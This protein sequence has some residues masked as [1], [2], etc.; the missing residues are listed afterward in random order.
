MA[1]V[2]SN[3]SLARERHMTKLK[4]VSRDWSF[5]EPEQLGCHF[6]WTASDRFLQHVL[7]SLACACVYH[8]WMKSAELQQL[9]ASEP[10]T[11]E[12]EYDMQR[13]W[14]ED[15]DKCTFII[16]DK[17]RWTDSGSEEAQCMIG[18]VNFFLSDPEDLSLA[19]LEIMI[20]EP[21]YRGKGIGKE[22]TQMMMHYGV[23]KL[24]IN[25]F[26]AK[27]GLDNEVSIS[28]FKKLHFHQVETMITNM[29]KKNN[30]DDRNRGNYTRIS[31]C[32]ICFLS[33][34]K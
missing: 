17:R 20:A 13:S 11:L 8:E 18:D 27:I 21:D 16:L 6:Q 9:T 22:V 34:G 33:E 4:Q 5:P 29:C 26:Q 28:M 19:E 15:A 3:H 24:G 31:I 14:R 30:V 2:T 1:Q 25:K 32:E 10:L 12:Q 23:A 7:C